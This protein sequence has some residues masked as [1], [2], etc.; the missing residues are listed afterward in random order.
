MSKVGDFMSSPVL[1]TGHDHFAHNAVQN[2]YTENVGALLVTEKGEY[3]GI[4]TKA[5]WMHKVLEK[6]GD[7][8]GIKVS[9]I[10]T[11]PIISLDKDE[12]LTEASKLMKENK[13]RHIAVTDDGE[14]IGMLSIKDL[15][16]YY[17]QPWNM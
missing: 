9:S 16:R 10:M 8:N 1:S 14:I 5:D 17:Q 6:D 3:V 15:E 13:C 4:V 12:S 11:S 7:P 2:M